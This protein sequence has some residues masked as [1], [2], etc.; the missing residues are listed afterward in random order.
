[1]ADPVVTPGT[2]VAAPAGRNGVSGR[3]GSPPAP[4]SGTAIR[5]RGPGAAPA[6]VAG[7]AQVRE[8]LAEEFG[9]D[10]PDGCPD[11]SP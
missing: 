3:G 4:R 1:M 7:D 6:P 10:V 5:D 2:V 9:V 8:V 11:L